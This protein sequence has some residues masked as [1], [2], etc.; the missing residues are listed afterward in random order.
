MFGSSLVD[1]YEAVEKHHRFTA[2]DFAG[3]NLDALDASFL[4]EEIKEG[5]RQKYF[6]INQ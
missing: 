1:D 4:S 5:V 6:L 2:A 3:C